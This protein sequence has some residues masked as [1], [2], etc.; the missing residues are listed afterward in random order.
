MSGSIR[1]IIFNRQPLGGGRGNFLGDFLDENNEPNGP[2]MVL[3]E[4]AAIIP[5]LQIMSQM[6]KIN[7]LI[8]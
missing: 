3:L 8:T 5:M 4:N 6:I 7:Q 1:F 2:T